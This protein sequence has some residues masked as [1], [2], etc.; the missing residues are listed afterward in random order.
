CTKE[1]LEA[2]TCIRCSEH[3]D[4]PLAMLGHTEVSDSAVP[5]TCAATG[6]TEGSHCSVCDA[7]LVAQEIVLMAPHTE[8]IDHAIPATCTKSGLTAG[9]HCSVCSEILVAQESIPALGHTWGD[10]VHAEGAENKDARHT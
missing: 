6:L 1:G 9:K 2:F 4:V 3:D 8:V 7:I 10:W 5:A